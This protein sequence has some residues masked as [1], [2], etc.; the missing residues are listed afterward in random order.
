VLHD[1]ELLRELDVR[2]GQQL[3]LGA[4]T[5]VSRSSLQTPSMDVPPSQPARTRNSR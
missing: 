2:A 1:E 5:H 3:V 4:C